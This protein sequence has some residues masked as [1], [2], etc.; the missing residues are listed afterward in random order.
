MQWSG[1]DPTATARPF[2]FSFLD[3]RLFDFSEKALELIAHT[4]HL[5]TMLGRELRRSWLSTSSIFM[6]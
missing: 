3:E 4:I 6:P 5:C 2:Y 1:N